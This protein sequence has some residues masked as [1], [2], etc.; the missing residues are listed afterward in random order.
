MIQRSL[1]QLAAITGG[2][3]LGADTEIRG[4]CTDS[5]KPLNGAL[6]VALRG[7][8]HDGHEHVDSALTAGCAAALIARDSGSFQGPVVEVEDTLSALGLIAA[9]WCKSSS[10]TVVAVTGSNGKTTVKNMLTSILARVDK[11]HSTD[12]NFNNEIGVPLTLASMPQDARFLVVEMGASQKGDIAYLCQLAKPNVGIV[13]NAGGAHL[14]GFGSIQGVAEAKGE[15]FSNLADDGCAV[16]NADDQ[17]AHLWRS[18]ASERRQLAFGSNEQADVRAIDV[19]LGSTSTFTLLSPSASIPVTLRRSGMH[20][21]RNAAAAAAAALALGVAADEICVGLAEFTPPPGRLAVTGEEGKWVVVD[22]SYNA[23]PSSLL[24]GVEAVS[25]IRPEV[26]V[27]LG[28]MAELGIDSD[29]LHFECGLQMKRA[30]VIRLFTLGPRARHC[31]LG[32]GDGAE[33][34]DDVDALASAVLSDIGST[35]AAVLIKG[36]RRMRMERVVQALQEAQSCC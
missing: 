11:T 26:W 34:F 13:T 12:G 24:A 2:R 28:D 18:L 20:D 21:V 19:H 15:M 17:F 3:Q 35:Q 32:F 31:A 16:I 5:R 6:F 8:N 10:A 14:K 33:A 30:N 7:E 36:S 1:Q 23:N 22:D 9:D 4:L 25:H 29:A 27:V